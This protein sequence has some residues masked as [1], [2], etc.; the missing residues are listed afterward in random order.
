[1][2]KK[3]NVLILFFLT[4]LFILIISCEKQSNCIEIYLI[5]NKRIKT[6]EGIPLSKVIGFNNDNNSFSEAFVNGTKYDTVRKKFILAG[7]FNTTYDQLAK[8]PLIIDSEIEFLDT[9]KSEIHLTSLGFKKIKDLKPDMIH[10]IQ[11]VVCNNKKPVFTGYFWSKYS[12][13][14]STWNC[15]EYNHLDT[16]DNNPLKLFK[17]DG[18]NQPIK[19]KIH[20]KKYKN[21]IEAF[22][23]SKRL[24]E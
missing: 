9:I 3:N 10:G 21:F 15:I 8:T 22:K 14:T 18:T 1:M 12:S 5:K 7:A 24:K 17:G 11:F 20:F 2:Y 4:L 16:I 13:Y 19:G 6:N 23:N